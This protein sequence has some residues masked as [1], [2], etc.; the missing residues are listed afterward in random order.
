MWTKTAGTSLAHEAA[1]SENGNVTTAIMILGS[2][3]FNSPLATKINVGVFVRL[4]RGVV[5]HLNTLNGMLRHTACLQSDLMLG[6]GC[7]TLVVSGWIL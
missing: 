5:V 2:S 3:V 4:L 6:I 7:L 1:I